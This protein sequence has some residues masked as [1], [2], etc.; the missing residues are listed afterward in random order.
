MEI[1]FGYSR[2]GKSVCDY[3][4]DQGIKD[5]AFCD[6]SAKKRGEEYRGVPV[7]DVPRAIYGGGGILYC[8]SFSL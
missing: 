6:N 7:M 2:L 1:I 3:L 5:I 8:Q 4:L